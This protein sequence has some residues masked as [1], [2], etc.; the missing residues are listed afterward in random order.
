MIALPP[1]AGAVQVTVAEL[2]AGTALTPVGAA[3]AVGA[4]GV[5][6][7]DAADEGPVPTALVADTLKVYAVPGVSPATTVEVTGGDPVTWTG[8]WAAVPM[9]GVTV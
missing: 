5:T 2:S 4:V 1:L 6:A 9:K 7:L 8:L 3:G